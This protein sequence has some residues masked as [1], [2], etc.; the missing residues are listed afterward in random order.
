MG[1]VMHVDGENKIT[2]H[3]ASL[4]E[5]GDVR[6]SSDER[7]I[8]DRDMKPNHVQQ[9]TAKWNNKQQTKPCT[10]A[11]SLMKQRTTNQTMYNNSQPNATTD[12]KQNNFQ[13]Q[14]A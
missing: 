6:R 7:N 9:Q 10:T 13:Q 11:V 12:N 1:K 5:H 3:G 2:H 4:S 14:S 8:P